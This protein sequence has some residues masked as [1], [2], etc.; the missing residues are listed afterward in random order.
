[1]DKNAIKKY[2]VQ[3]RMELIARIKQRA[4]LYEITEGGFGD[5]EA[6]TAHGRVLTDEEKA[7]RRALVARIRQEGYQQVMEEVAYT[8]FNRFI[9]LRFM[10]VNGYLP[11]H[12]RVFTDENNQF[13]PQILAEAMNLELDGLDPQK[14]YAF[15]T[16]NDDDGLFKYMIIVQC[17]ALSAILPRMFQRI[18]D[19]TELL[20][21]DNLLR[22]GS[23]VEQMISAIPEDDWRDAVQI[24]GWLYQYYNAEKK[25]EVFAALKKNVKITKENIPAATQLFTPDWIV[26]YMVENSLGRLWVE[27]HPNDD[28]KAN[29]KYYLEEAE[30][31]PDVQ[32]Q[33]AEIRKEYAAMTPE[34]IKCI[35][36]CCGSG[37][38]LAY[39]FDV[40][41]QIYESYGYTTREAVE[42][43]VR[44]NLYGLDIDDRAAQL[45]YFAVMMKARQY[46]RRFFS[47]GL[48][49][50]I[51]AIQ[52]SNGI[53]SFALDYFCNGDT[54]LKAAI[55][56]II[57]EMHDAKEYGSILNIT[58]VDFSALY[59]RFDKV[60]DD[61]SMN[62]ESVLNS[63]LSLV[64]VAHTLAQ[65]YD[66][67]VTNPPYMGSSG[68]GAKLAEF[69][70]KNYPDS[71][72]DLFAVFIEACGGMTKQ[73]GYQAM[74][75]Q[76]AWMFL[77][78]FEK[79]RDKLLQ[80]D[81]MN[82]AHLGARAFDEIG[83]EVVQTTSFVLRS[84]RIDEYKGTYCRLIE[85]TSEQGK[86]DMFLA[87][88]NRYTA[89]QSN[90]SKIPGSPVAYWVSTAF[91]TI[92]TSG[93][94]KDV[95]TTRKGMFTGNNDLWLKFWQEIS[96][97]KFGHQY[98]P[99]NKG[100]PYRKWY[101]NN[102]YV[103]NWGEN[104]QAIKSFKGSGNINDANNFLK[105]VTWSLI[106][107]GKPSFR[108]IDDTI[109]VMGDAGPISVFT[110]E[111]SLYYALAEL[112]SYI[113]EEASYIINPTINCSSGTVS[114]FPL[115]IEKSRKL[116]VV[117]LSKH[118]VELCHTDWDSFEN[119]W[120]F[121]KHPLV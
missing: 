58:P 70:K 69:V 115:K 74:I 104:G 62:K 48:Q 112:N 80:K 2:A 89:Q 28:L 77:S 3:A 81:T 88:K 99:Y 75:T 29:W 4:A 73:N 109:H 107:S 72:S 55:D 35:D 56:S 98:K 116:D 34:Q 43:I 17:N 51:Y 66:V 119:S 114:L 8:W 6:Q 110:D 117:N 52:E 86:E 46:D 67:V 7:Q 59:A 102:D 21:P 85:P 15:K 20:F 71:K 13:K 61:I 18:S 25:D 42:S 24:I 16:T 37:H 96:F 79:L 19:Y 50:N 53:D 68:M 5:L 10:E 27:G 97:E 31:E 45:A 90:F 57:T 100:G 54:K 39:L 111:V 26:R 120:D 12:V 32:M 82:M 60:R 36:P 101:G 87:G 83:G 92:F 63:L 38:I 49:P 22:E 14:V 84:S 40:L 106:T 41:V 93:L 121:K 65:K 78:S 118:C 47:R 105:C 30:Q 108:L 91:L 76:H 23:V 94:L 64:Q 95:G 44:N 113:A 1:M 103:V 11:S 33:L 9:A